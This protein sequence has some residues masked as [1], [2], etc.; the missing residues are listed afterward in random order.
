MA[1]YASYPGGKLRDA[2]GLLAIV[3]ALFTGQALPVESHAAYPEKPLRIVVPFPPGGGTD[4]ISRNLG[5]GLRM[6]FGQPVVIDNRPG[7]GTII[8]TSLVAKSSPDGYTLVMSSFAHAVNPSLHAKLPYGEKSLTPVVLVARSSNILVTHP[9]SAFRNVGDLIGYGK[10]NPEKVTYGSFGNGT[11][12]HLAGELFASLA[13]IRM[14]HVPYRGSGPALTDLLGGRLSV[15]FAT[16][17]SAGPLIRTKRLRALAVTSTSRSPAYPD[18]PT[19]AEAGVPGYAA[20]GWYGLYAPAGTPREIVLRINAAV[21]R[22]VQSAAY[23]KNV[24]AEGLI[25]STGS[26]EDMAR[27]VAGEEARWRKV[28]QQARITAD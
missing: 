25:P 4:L 24:E 16:S 12:G 1:I 27:Y 18:L 21:K 8:G 13:K 9:A 5:N 15:I 7:A 26:P 20:E 28:V 14:V 23:R 11:S 17:G 22:V 6:E 10:E 3:V 19:I 2:L